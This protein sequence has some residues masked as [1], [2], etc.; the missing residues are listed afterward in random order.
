[1]LKERETTDEQVKQDACSTVRVIQWEI[2][3]NIKSD[4]I[5]VKNRCKTMISFFTYTKIILGNLP[6]R[7]S[8]E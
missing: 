3:I 8:Q 7:N 5:V 4:D 6:L 1:M 2:D